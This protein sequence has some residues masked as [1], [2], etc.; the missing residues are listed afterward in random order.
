MIITKKSNDYMW[1]MDQMLY[2]IYSNKTYP[3]SSSMINDPLRG[4]LKDAHGINLNMF[5]THRFIFGSHTGTCEPV[6]YFFYEGPY[7]TIKSFF[8]DDDF[9]EYYGRK[10]LGYH[11]EGVLLGFFATEFRDLEFRKSHMREYADFIYFSMFHFV[12]ERIIDN[13][14]YSWYI[15]NIKLI[16]LFKTMNDDGVDITSLKDINYKPFYDCVFS[17]EYDYDKIITILQNKDAFL[18]VVRSYNY[19]FIFN[20]FKRYDALDREHTKEEY[21]ELREILGIQEEYEEEFESII[22]GYKQ[23]DEKPEDEEVLREKKLRLEETAAIIKENKTKELHVFIYNPFNDNKYQ[24]A[25]ICMD[26]KTTEAAI[27]RMDNFIYTTCTRVVTSDMIRKGYRIFIHLDE[28]KVNE[29]KI[30][31][32]DWT[33]KEIRWSHR[34][35]EFLYN[36]TM[37]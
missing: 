35:E 17:F 31:E 12:N 33:D 23:D 18:H 3:N 34:L 11:P 30:G 5:D 36:G 29:I 25:A 1:K 20:F 7:E 21:K 37:S 15:E 27:E 6:E 2:A 8:K 26:Y 16:Y 28:E 4:V 19:A 32:N 10:I 24:H 22:K 9:S 13:G 14:A